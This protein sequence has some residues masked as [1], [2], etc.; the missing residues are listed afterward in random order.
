MS[1]DPVTV[2]VK[3]AL[4][5]ASMALTASQRFEGPR[6]KTTEVSVADYGSP[7]PEVDG[8]CRIDGCLISWSK[9]LREE[10]VES[11]TKGGKFSDYRYFWTGFAV[12]A[13]H[14]C[15][16]IAKIRMDNHLVFDLTKA[17]PI[18]V[19]SGFFQ[20]ISSDSPVKLNLGE[21]LRIYLGTDDQEVDPTYAAWCEDRYGPDSATARREICGAMFV[22][23]PVEKFGNR[24]PQISMDVV[25]N[26]D[27]AYLLES[28][29]AS[30][31]LNFFQW[32]PD[33]TRFHFNDKIWDTATRQVI[34]P[35]PTVSWDV[36]FISNGDYYIKAGV[37]GDLYRC[38]PD[39]VATL[40]SYTSTGA[41][42]L[43][44]GGR[45]LWGTP[46]FYGFS[47]SN[48][49]YLSDPETIT[50]V[51]LDG[52]GLGYYFEESG[53]S[54]M[55]VGATGTTLYF[56]TLPNGSYQT[57]TSP[58]SSSTVY[59]FDN[60]QGEYFVHHG[61]KLLL[62]DKGTMTVTASIDAPHNS[63][64]EKFYRHTRIGQTRFWLHKSEIDTATLE[65]I[66]TIDTTPWGTFNSQCLYDPI[67]HALIHSNGSTLTWLFLDRVAE[68]STTLGS[69]TQGVC[70]RRGIPSDAFDVTELTQLVKG[71]WRIQGTGA[72]QLSAPLDIHDVDC[73]PHDFGIKF[74][75]RGAAADELIEE[76]D[77]VNRFEI[78]PG[79]RTRLPTR[80]E[81]NYADHTA[82]QQPNT[83]SHSIPTDASGSEHKKVF[84]LTTFVSDPDEAQP[85]VERYL[86]RQF[87]FESEPGEA[88]LTVRWTKLEPGDVKSIEI[89]GEQRAV[90]ITEITRQ[91]NLVTA[92][93][94]R[95]DPRV[96][97][98]NASAGPT[99]DGRDLEEI[100]I[101]AP[102]KSVVM[103]IPYLNDAEN[104]TNPQL[105]YGMGTYTGGNFPGGL[106]WQGA[107]ENEGYQQ[108]N[109]VESAEKAV[110]GYSSGALGD[111]NPWLWDRGNVL[112]VGLGGG[113]LTSCTEA[114]IDA[115]PT[116]N[117]A[118]IGA[119]GR[120]EIINFT[121]ATL[122]GD[123]VWELSGFK[124]GR[125][126]TEM[127]TGNH[128]D[129]D[130]FWLAEDLK[131][132]AFGLSDVGTDVYFKGQTLGRD[133]VSAPTIALT[134]EGQSL[135]PYAPAQLNWTTDGTDL[136]GEIIRR[137]R[138][139][140]SWVG[141]TTIPLSEN[142]EAY[143]VDIMDGVDVVRTITVTGTNEFTYTAAQ[144]SA[145]GNTV[146]S[147]P[148]ANVYQM[149]DAVGRGFALAA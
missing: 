109:G 29:S 81:F 104:N 112:T 85:L 58:V 142:S 95:D 89:D 6:L 99:F 37:S 76:G 128:A 13:G 4:T 69:I 134:L 73:C 145:D 10:E 44:A 110:W 5:A 148:D 17:G 129:G 49:Y 64:L 116:L 48:V 71:Y 122:L 56:Y 27:A 87:Y 126:G 75:V 77:F 111:A 141:G 137:T 92:R 135:K 100:Y 96:H 53:G 67:N 50:G 138:I 11:K 72:D 114:E 93:W 84:D 62:I 3:I 52:P 130:E 143:E 80:V 133:L 106:I 119:Q 28:H 14:E 118:V 79:P 131:A 120:W 68:G 61:S 33:Q 26:P 8:Y 144:L 121:S 2:G 124:R 59:A 41:S 108:W 74:R 97:D 91:G 40:I 98:K 25:N 88:A 127:N 38:T 94:V 23:I 21:N 57:A 107:Y 125:R 55:A 66:R 1:V 7:F 15:D 60:G 149:S 136:F 16:A 9:P 123:D 12:G 139:G 51:D 54:A 90:R 30:G 32:T 78:A 146:A 24:V 86:R 65:I 82:D 102:S 103:D 34:I 35:D 70:V 43:S 132:D 147:P 101:P 36:C 39:G 140:G 115:D 47:N 45:T 31:D 42:G 83:A 113:T 63:N 20:M 22:D 46:Y 19:M 18:S 105:H 117:M